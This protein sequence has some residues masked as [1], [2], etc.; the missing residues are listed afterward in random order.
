M[1]DR[2]PSRED[3]ILDK[4][5][6]LERNLNRRLDEQDRALQRVEAQ[7]TKTNGRVTELENARQRGLGVIA[8]YRWIPVVVGSGLAAGL[9]LLGAALAGGFH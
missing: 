6:T 9:S 4:I 8:A 7:T 3:L 2:D 5:N 1:P